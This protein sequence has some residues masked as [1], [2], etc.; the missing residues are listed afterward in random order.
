MR[1]LRLTRVLAATDLTDTS[2]AALR[3][4]ARLAGSAG[5]A[6]HVAYVA[7]KQTGII[8]SGGKRSEYQMELSESMGRIGDVPEFVPHVLEGEPSS[9]LAAAADRVGADVIVT[10]RRRNTPDISTDR[11]L[12]GTAY[13]VITRST[14]PCLAI[15]DEMRVP[16]GRVL[17]AIDWSEASRGAM[18]V[19]LS[20]ASA[21]RS[22]AGEEPL[23]SVLHVHKHGDATNPSAE[24]RVDH[25]LDILRRNAG[26]WASVQV[27]G[28]T[29]P[30]N[31][32][33]D[34]VARLAHEMQVDL[35]VAGTRGLGARRDGTLGSVSAQLLSR[36]SAPVLLVPP[37]V[38][39]TYAKDLD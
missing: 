33:P 24:Q 26:G 37:A 22:R 19:G 18:L 16:V 11:P 25:E 5:A 23:M 6:L 28:T 38:W 29:M 27:S 3:S 30:G 2:T 21:L 15:T 4:A 32:I 13:A 34:V 20:W 17:V 31:D 10:G 7:P 9:A 36:V 8:A 12:G 1:L 14:I 35:L 39:Q